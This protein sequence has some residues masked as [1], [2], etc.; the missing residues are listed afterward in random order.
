MITKKFLKTKDECE[1]C[2]ELDSTDAEK[3][4]LVCEA[5]GWEPIPMKKGKTGSFRAR[6]RVPKDGRFQYRYLVD[7]RA[8]VNDDKADGFLTNEFGTQNCVLDTASSR[9]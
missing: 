8:W 4:E 9:P 6:I 1:V 2:F 5:N 7:R 3:V